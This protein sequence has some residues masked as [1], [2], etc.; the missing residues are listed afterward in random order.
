MPKSTPTEIHY[1]DFRIT[2]MR[3]GSL[4]VTT[5]LRDNEPAATVETRHEGAWVRISK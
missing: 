1:G 5:K 3:D 4:V 2:L